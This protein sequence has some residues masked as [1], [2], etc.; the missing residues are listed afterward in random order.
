MLYWQQI[1]NN[2]SNK[3]IQ[4]GF[5]IDNLDQQNFHNKNTSK[6]KFTRYYLS[7]DMEHLYLTKREAGC[8][9][10]ILQGYSI[11]ATAIELN[12]S[13]RT[14][15]FYFK[16]IKLK[17]NCQTRGEL[18]KLLLKNDVLNMLKKEENLFIV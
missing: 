1:I 3:N 10:Y 2:V 7:D 18:I 14:V 6:R 8:I 15:E 11:K 4:C 5:D 17:F 16:R 13:P 12:L 9:F